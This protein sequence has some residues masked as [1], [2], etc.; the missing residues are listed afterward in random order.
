MFVLSFSFKK[1]PER[2]Q[3]LFEWKIVLLTW[4]FTTASLYYTSVN[5]LDVKMH[6]KQTFDIGCFSYNTGNAYEH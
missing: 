5:D 1:G 3:K 6:A 4:E 2:T